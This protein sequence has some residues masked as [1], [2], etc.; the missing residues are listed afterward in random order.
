MSESQN[1]YGRSATRGL[2][3]NNKMKATNTTLTRKGGNHIV[4]AQLYAH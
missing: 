2:S 3:Q 1:L 4:L